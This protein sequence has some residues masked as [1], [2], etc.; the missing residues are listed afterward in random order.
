[1]A[2]FSEK[3]GQDL[4]D[5][6]QAKFIE[7]NNTNLSRIYPRGTRTNSSNYDPIPYWFG[8]CQL[9]KKCN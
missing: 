8:G 2:S 6:D 1:M 4:L 9:G 5:I 7:Y 3:H